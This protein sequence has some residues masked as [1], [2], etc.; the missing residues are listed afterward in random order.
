M[1]MQHE[2]VTFLSTLYSFK[3]E[4]CEAKS[5]ETFQKC[6]LM[7]RLNKHFKYV[8]FFALSKQGK[9]KVKS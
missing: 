1:Q 7:F 4:F 6:K 5:C 2:A 8:F 9:K 3:Y